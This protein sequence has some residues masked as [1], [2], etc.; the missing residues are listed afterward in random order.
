ITRAQLASQEGRLL[1]GKCC[2]PFP[3]SRSFGEAGAPHGWQ[4][5]V[6][7]SM[8]VVPDLGAVTERS[9]CYAQV[10]LDEMWVNRSDPL[11]D[12]NSIST[13]SI[14]AIE[15]YSGPSE[16]PAKYSKMESRCGTLVIHTRKS[17][18]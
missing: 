13:S 15:F 4:P 11:F 8:T 18:K 17:R 3:D 9:Y 1:G 12:I 2:R 14:A 7:V 10:Y 5:A 16:T 6:R